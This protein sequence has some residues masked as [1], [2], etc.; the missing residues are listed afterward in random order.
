MLQ[1]IVPSCTVHTG[2]NANQQ[3][4]RE[5]T[6]N[7]CTADYHNYATKECPACTTVFCYDCCHSTNL[8]Q[9][10]KHEPDFMLCPNCHGD[11]FSVEADEPQHWLAILV[12]DK[13]ARIV[14]DPDGSGVWFD[15]TNYR[16]V[17]ADVASRINSGAL[18]LTDAV[19]VMNS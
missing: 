5:H 8:D 6:M 4:H 3:T 12:N 15:R 17:P 19:A 7:H 1:Y 14:P 18:T 2:N 16:E 10:G 13:V 11:W 9:G